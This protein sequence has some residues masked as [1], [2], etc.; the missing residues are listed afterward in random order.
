MWEMPLGLFRSERGRQGGQD[1]EKQKRS[2]F[3]SSWVLFN[4]FFE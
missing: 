2:G 1:L 4:M 3:A